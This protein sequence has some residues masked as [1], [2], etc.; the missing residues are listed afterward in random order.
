MPVEP[1][2]KASASPCRKGIAANPAGRVQPVRIEV[3]GASSVH[4]AIHHNGI[5]AGLR[6]YPH[7]RGRVVGKA[8][9]HPKIHF[10][11]AIRHIAAA[12]QKKPA[13]F[14]PGIGRKHISVGISRVSHLNNEIPKIHRIAPRAIQL[15]PFI[16]QIRSRRIVQHFIQHHVPRQL[17]GAEPVERLGSCGQFLSIAPSVPVG[18]GIAGVGVVNKD[19]SAVGQPVAVGILPIGNGIKPY[20]R[21]AGY[22][23]VFVHA[24]AIRQHQIGCQTFPRAFQPVK[25]WRHLMPYRIGVR[26]HVG[27]L[28]GP[29]DHNHRGRVPDGI[30]E[31]FN[32][33]GPVRHREQHR[34]VRCSLN[35]ADAE[36]A[37]L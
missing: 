33:I 20:P 22:V 18:V 16:A 13:G 30:G 12:Q 6:H 17:G 19:F 5:C 28:V 3:A 24:N 11:I 29:R 21:V 8:I 1:P 35:V 26:Y 27:L 14:N 37:R 23:R 9:G 36:L 31:N 10:Q 34:A 32:H 15:N 2:I 25:R 4:Q 7:C